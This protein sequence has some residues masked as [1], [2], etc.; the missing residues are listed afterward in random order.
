MCS[1][2]VSMYVI[3]AV[4][5]SFF[6]LFVYLCS[7]S[8][9]VLCPGSVLGFALTLKHAVCPITSQIKGRNGTK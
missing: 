9:Y 5:V 4:C 1:A 7:M 3:P 8:C 6:C 2:N